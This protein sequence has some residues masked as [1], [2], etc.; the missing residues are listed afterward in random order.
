M[1]EN[2]YKFSNITDRQLK[3]H[4]VQAL[5]DRPNAAQQFGQSGLSPMQLKL[6]FDKLATLIAS[7]VNELQDAITGPNAAKYIGAALGEYKTFDELFEGMQDGSFSATLLQVFPNETAEM[8]APLQDVIF[9]IAQSFA[10]LETSLDDID[11]DKLDKVTNT[12]TYRRLYAVSKTGEQLNINVS[13]TPLADS[14]PA[15]SEK[16]NLKT[17]MPSESY[18]AVPYAYIL[19]MQR[20]M[21]A[22]VNF[23]MDP[24][25]FIV[26]VDVVNPEGAIIYHTTLDLPLESFVV[27]GGYA[28]GIVKFTLK[29][30]EVIEVP[31]SHIV[32]GLV[33]TAEHKADIDKL[34]EKVDT[35]LAGY[36]TEVYDI[37]G[38]DYVDYSE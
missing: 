11:K 25:T 7:K 15:Y 33:T 17:A 1:E 24:E 27:G 13:E 23:T 35:A 22:G 26:S 19:E 34:N 14:I 36:I 18:H 5:A 32:A 3:Q 6:W 9:G 10:E 28:D 37:V 16:G 2:K 20:H 12:A 30:G 8:V 21:G 29:S 31:I 4:G 38:G